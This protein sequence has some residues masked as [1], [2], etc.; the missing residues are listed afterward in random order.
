ME[1][2]PVVSEVCINTGPTRG[3]RGKNT[4]YHSVI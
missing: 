2:W 1:R 4:Y 3:V